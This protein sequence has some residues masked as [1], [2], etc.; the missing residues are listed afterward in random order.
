MALA[1]INGGQLFKMDSTIFNKKV[2]LEALKS[3]ISAIEYIPDELYDDKEIVLMVVSNNGHLLW[4]V[5]DRL[6]DDI[7][8]VKAAIRQNP[9]AIKFASQRLKDSD[10]I[11]SILSEEKNKEKEKHQE[12]VKNKIEQFKDKPIWWQREDIVN[13][14]KLDNSIT[15]ELVKDVED[16]L[17]Y[18]LPKSYID[19]L[20]TQNGGRLIKKYYVLDDKI[21]EIDCIYGISEYKGIVEKNYYLSDYVD[22]DNVVVFGDNSHIHYLFDYSDTSNGEP[23]II[24]YDDELD[25]KLVLANDFRQFIDNLKTE[26][27]INF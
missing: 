6:I 1:K 22:L 7:D 20:N 3:N 12:E 23:K 24:C 11:K 15:E 17:H 18:K 2:I 9:E 8:V 4:K 21:F 16:K 27:E 14:E 25:E 13:Y 19:L 10:E 26:E 5:S